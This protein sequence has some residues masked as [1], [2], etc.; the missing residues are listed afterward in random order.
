LPKLTL[1]VPSLFWPDAHDDR[2][3]AGLDLPSLQ[4]FIARSELVARSCADETQWLCSRFGVRRQNDWPVGAL[5]LLGTGTDPGGLHWFRADPVH[6]DARRDRLVLL[7]LEPGSLSA[8]DANAMVATLNLHF[9]PDGLHFMA[10]R[11]DA[12]FARFSGAARITT[13]PLANAIGRDVQ[14]L[15]PEGEDRMPWHRLINEVQMLLHADPV[16]EE[17]ER[18]HI[19]PVNSVWFWGGGSLPEVEADFD[20]VFGHSDLLT[21]LCRQGGI[22][23]GSSEAGPAALTGTRMLLALG[24]AQAAARQADLMAWQRALREMETVW[25]DPLAG[26]LRNGGLSQVTLATVAGGRAWEWSATRS[27]LWK[28]WK[29]AGPLAVTARNLASAK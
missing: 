3:H 6:L 14:T 7:P 24:N 12:W 23:I 22:P 10:P 20:T 29:R 5:S 16:N 15:L 2:A 8:A 27:D 11:P 9:G 17:R 13:T 1:F 25:F 18:R 19:A 21:G 4:G 26:R 28:F